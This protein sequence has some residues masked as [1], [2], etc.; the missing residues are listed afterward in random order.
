MLGP[1]AGAN[2]VFHFRGMAETVV[3][4]TQGDPWRAGRGNPADQERVCRSLR[5]RPLLRRAELPASQ[6]SRPS[7]RQGAA[8]D[9]QESGVQDHQRFSRGDYAVTEGG[10]NQMFILSDAGM[11][12][13]SLLLMLKLTHLT[14]F[15][16]QQY[17]CELL[18]LGADT[19]DRVKALRAAGDTVLLL[20]ALDEDRTAWGKIEQRPPRTPHPH[21]PLP[22]G[23]HFLPH[24]V[25]S[26]NF[27]RTRLPIRAGSS[28]AASSVP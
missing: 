23:H 22:A 1:Y 28:S 3:E 12:K 8:I 27:R 4:E 25:L 20:D 18:K 14:R 10:R 15:W 24:P 6:P 11:G 21:Q 17:H 16:P 9:G 5:T 7:G 26:R 2:N 13:T 19:L